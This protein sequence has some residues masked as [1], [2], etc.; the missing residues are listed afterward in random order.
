VSVRRGVVAPFWLDRPAEEALALAPTAENLGYGEFWV[1]EMLHFDAFALAGAIAQATSRITVTAGPVALGLRDPVSLAMGVG[2]VEIIGGRP[3][4]L[5]IGSS[6]RAVVRAWHGRAH[7]GEAEKITEAIG[8]VRTVLAGERT[9]H[10]GANFH[11]VGFRSGLGQR[12]DHITVAAAGFRMVDAAAQSAD[13]V[14]VN[15]VTPER[16]ALVRDRSGL[17]LA[18]WVVAAV[19]PTPPGIDQIRRQLVLYLTAPGYRESLRDAGMGSV[20]DEVAD[21]ARPKDVA[22]LITTEMISA[23]AAIGSPNDVASAVGAFEQTGAEVMLVPVTADDHG[24]VR[25]L[26][27]LA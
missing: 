12:T 24:G 14:V 25:T 15:L 2:S 23:I 20:V 27:G 1:G 18:V 11:S 17:P 9:E 7:G 10:R 22:R 16:A 26:R 13:R 3:A 21:G 19:E 8:L 5:A 6:S 4:R